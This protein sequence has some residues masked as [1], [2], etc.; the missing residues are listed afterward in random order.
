DL[1]ERTRAI[2]V[3]E[4]GEFGLVGRLT[5]RFAGS[6]AAAPVLGPGDDAAVLAATFP[7]SDPPP[8]P[9]T[10][11]G[12]VARGRGVVVDGSAYEAPGGWDHFR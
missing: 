1:I 10:V 4:V 3:A 11:I 2:T 9:W 7:G 5:A 12:R 6:T 8:A